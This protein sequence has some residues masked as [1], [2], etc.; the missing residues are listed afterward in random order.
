M[1]ERIFIPGEKVVMRHRRDSYRW[2]APMRVVEDRGD[3]VALY[4]QPG[5]T[6]VRMGN[7]AGESTRD[8]FAA[9]RIIESTW[10]E[11]HALQLIRFGD[12]HATVLYWREGTWEFRCWYINFQ[13]PL[14]RFER[15]FET[16]DLTLDLLISPDRTAWQWKDEDEFANGIEFGW[17]SQEQ[18]A[19]LK[20]Y[21]GRV[22]RE[23]QAGLPPFDGNWPAWRPDPTWEPLT[24]PSD[25][26]R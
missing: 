21:G 22:I 7:D 4:T 15:G 19:I 14:R 18:L 1:S 5:D 25:W 24:L 3:F 20:T 17:Y 8:F 9:T 2:A 16:M 13:E 10:N 12:E 23:A 6:Y 26:D 11:N